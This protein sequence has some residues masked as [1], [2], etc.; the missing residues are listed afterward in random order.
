MNI[1]GRFAQTTAYVPSDFTGAFYGSS[2]VGNA[3]SG[4]QYSDANHYTNLD[5]SRSWTGNT[6][7][8]IYTNSIQNSSTVQPP[9]YIVNIWERIA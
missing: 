9:A 4:G 7:S 6:S 5:A 3:N 1:T 8:P 2:G